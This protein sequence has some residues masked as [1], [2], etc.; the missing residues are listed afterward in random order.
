MLIDFFAEWCMPCI[1]MAPIIEEISD[2]F[3][4]KIKVGKVNVGDNPKIAEKFNVS[5]IP[6]FTVFKDGKPVKQFI[7]SMSEEELESRLKSFL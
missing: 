5:S 4:G 3:K 7:G 2:A 6:N 1:V